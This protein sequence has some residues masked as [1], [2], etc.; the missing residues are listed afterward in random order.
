MSDSEADFLEILNIDTSQRAEDYSPEKIWSPDWRVGLPASSEF[1]LKP[2]EEPVTR[3][4]PDY[5]AAVEYALE[6][7]MKNVDPMD[8]YRD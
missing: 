4:D 2:G 6:A 8:C 7:I 1:A 3:D 5:T